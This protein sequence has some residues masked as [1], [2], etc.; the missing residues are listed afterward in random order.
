M[1]Y[2]FKPERTISLGFNLSGSTVQNWRKFL[3]ARIII[4][5]SLSGGPFRKLPANPKPVFN[6]LEVHVAHLSLGR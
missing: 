1:F 6:R 4:K 3:K 2:L 5:N